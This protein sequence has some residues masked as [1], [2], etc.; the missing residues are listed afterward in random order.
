[1]ALHAA[2]F[3]VGLAALSS[4]NSAFAVDLTRGADRPPVDFALQGPTLSL[5]FGRGLPPV[6]GERNGCALGP[7]LAGQLGIRVTPTLDVILGFRHVW[8]DPNSSLDQPSVGLASWLPT[9]GMLLARGYAAAGPVFYSGA[10]GLEG[11]IAADLMISPARWL[12]FGVTGETG[13]GWFGGFP[14][15]SLHVGAVIVIRPYL[16]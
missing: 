3:T 6:C 14:L 15:V 11:H 1:M 4:A 2:W 5:Y 12:G 10:S 16:W 8:T 9:Q 7:G 13:L